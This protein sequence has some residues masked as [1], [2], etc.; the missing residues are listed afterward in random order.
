MS[1]SGFISEW[2]LTVLAS[3]F[4]WIGLPALALVGLARLVRSVSP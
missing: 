2:G 3:E 4:V 1:I